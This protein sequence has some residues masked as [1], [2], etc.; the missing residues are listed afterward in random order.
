MRKYVYT[1]RRPLSLP[2]CC[3]VRAMTAARC[4]GRRQCRRSA[5]RRCFLRELKKYLFIEIYTYC[6]RVALRVQIEIYTYCTNT[7]VNNYFMVRVHVYSTVQYNYTCTFVFF[8]YL[9]PS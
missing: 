5:L 9:L 3:L 4:R 7:F 2:F 1:Y 6:T 8:V